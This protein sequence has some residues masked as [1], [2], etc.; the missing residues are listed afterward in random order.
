MS[1]TIQIN[2]LKCGNY[3]CPNFV[4]GFVLRDYKTYHI[5]ARV[6]YTCKRDEIFSDRRRCFEC[7]ELV[8]KE[9]KRKNICLNCNYKIH[10][11]YG[12]SLRGISNVFCK[13]CGTDITFLRKGYKYCSKECYNKFLYISVIRPYRRKHGYGIDPI[14]ADCFTCG[15]QF[16]KRF[17]RNIHCSVK[18]RRINQYKKFKEKWFWYGGKWNLRNKTISNNSG[19]ENNV[20]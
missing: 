5:Q 15:K 14:M 13:G 3:D 20:K 16:R 17:K 10:R 6:C 18:C 7:S 12:L 11:T 4:E 8:E 1:E 2:K 9:S 19:G